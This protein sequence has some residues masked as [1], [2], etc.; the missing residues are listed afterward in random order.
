MTRFDSPEG[1]QIVVVY[2]DITDIKQAEAD[3]RRQQEMLLRNE[4]LAAMGILLASVTHELNNPLA[5]IK[6][7]VDLLAEE[8]INSALHERVTEVLQA[9]GR[10]MRIVHNFLTLARLLRLEGHEVDTA[11]GWQSLRHRVNP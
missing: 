8:A 7:Q 9:A 6:M 10:C 5:V 1:L 4:K 3:I 11:L 2:E